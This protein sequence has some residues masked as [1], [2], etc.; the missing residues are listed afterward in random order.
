MQQGYRRFRSF[1]RGWAAELGPRHIRVNVLVPGAILTPG[2]SGLSQSEEQHKAF[3]AFSEAATPL[4]RMA[5]PPEIAAAALFLA[6]DASSFVNASE[7]HADGGA[8]QI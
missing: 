1:A 6:S 8:G 3:V 4:G 2:W 7:L 5:D